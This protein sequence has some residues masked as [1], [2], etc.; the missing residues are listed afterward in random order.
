[1]CG[2]YTVTRPGDVLAEVW[3]ALEGTAL[4]LQDRTAAAVPEPRYNLAPTQSAAVVVRARDRGAE[5]AVLSRAR[6]GLAPRA[7]DGKPLINARLETASSLPTFAEAFVERRCLVPA[8]GFYEWSRATGQPH[9]FSVH[10]RAG[11]CFAGLWQGGTWDAAPS[12]RGAAETSLARAFCILT[13]QAAP[14][15]DDV[16]HRMPLILAPSTYGLWLAQGGLA[17]HDLDEIRGA[18]QALVLERRAVSQRVNRVDLDEPAL[19]QPA[20][21][22]PENLRL[23]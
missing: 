3:D 14:P 5:R 15:V 9:W 10:G 20:E 23:F 12:P 2:R 1:M 16:H 17:A 19:L 13:T 6:W 21:P 8:D 4:A 7:G 11:F 22:A 18:R